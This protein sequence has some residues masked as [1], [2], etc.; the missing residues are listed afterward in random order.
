[1]YLFFKQ[2]GTKALNGMVYMLTS[3][4]AYISKSGLAKFLINMIFY[5]TQSGIICDSIQI[6]QVGLDS[7]QCPVIS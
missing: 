1:M 3:K 4:L 6:S 2:Q 5:N 7:G